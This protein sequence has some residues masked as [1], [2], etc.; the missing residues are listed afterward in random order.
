MSV[1]FNRQGDA[2]Y[3]IGHRSTQFSIKIFLKVPSLTDNDLIMKNRIFAYH[4]GV[5]I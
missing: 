2:I 3:A 5:Y 1:L 4:R